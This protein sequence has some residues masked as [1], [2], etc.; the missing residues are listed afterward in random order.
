M[1]MTNYARPGSFCQ[2]EGDIF[3]Q[4]LVDVKREGM[5]EQADNLGRKY[6]PGLISGDRRRIRS[7]ANA[8]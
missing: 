8:I 1:A 3:L 7:A 5:K 6:A 2:M 4:I